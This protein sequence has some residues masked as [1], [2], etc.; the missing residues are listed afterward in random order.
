RGNEGWP[1]L[2]EQPLEGG[3]TS[4]FVDTS[5][6]RL[7]FVVS[8][9]FAA[10]Y[11]IRVASHELP[12]QTFPAGKRGAGLRYRR[13]SLY[14]SL[15]PGIPPQMP[16]LVTVTGKGKAKSYRLEQNHRH[17]VEHA[18]ASP[19]VSKEACR[20]LHPRLVTYDLRLS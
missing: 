9:E 4:R 3:S 19:A 20:K 6:E 2:C 15:H 17:F 13:T 14:P 7:E 5:I 1:L 12:L 8:R 16:L 10:R 18:G 11:K